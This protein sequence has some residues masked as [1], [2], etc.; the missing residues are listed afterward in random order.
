MTLFVIGTILGNMSVAYAATLK[1]A[2][3]DVEGMTCAACGVTLKAAVKKVAGVG[4]V[5]ASVEEKRAEVEFDASLAGVDDI[6]KAIDATGY[7]ATAKQC[8]GG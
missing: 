5:T 4:S 6:K 3:F 1:K 2:C 8:R 7:K